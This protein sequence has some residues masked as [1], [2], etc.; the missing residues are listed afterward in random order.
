MSFVCSLFQ[1]F[2]GQLDIVT[3]NRKV[4][5]Y[6]CFERV[7]R[8]GALASRFAAFKKSYS[9]G[10]GG[11]SGGSGGSSGGGSG[12]VKRPV[13]TSPCYVVLFNDLL[14]CGS[15]VSGRAEQRENSCWCFA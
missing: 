10:S 5:E 9:G 1:L 11:S 15:K 2:G 13:S 4:I 6:A 12:S 3:P 14:V 8:A 7:Y